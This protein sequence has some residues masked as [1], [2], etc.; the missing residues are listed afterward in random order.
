MGTPAI[1]AELSLKFKAAIEKR[2][3]DGYSPMGVAGGKGSS[4]LA[5]AKDLHIDQRRLNSWVYRQRKNEAAGKEHFSPDWNLW[6]RAATSRGKPVIA[7]ARRWLLTACQNDTPVHAGFWKNLTAYAEHIGAEI[8]VGPFTYQ[9]G[10]FT[11]HTTRNN[12]FAEQVRPF[13]RFDR[14]ECGN[15]LFCAE[16][17]TLPTAN[18]PL[19]GLQTYTR[20]QWGVFP[21]AKV[22]LETVPA[23]PGKDPPIIMTTGCCTVE[24]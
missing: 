16:M 7:A 11:D 1:A 13:L 12:V 4:V 15:V 2:L 10:T 17:N 21:H 3:R 8:L 22:A 23:M 19:S 14:Q 20:G 6:N 24:H 5:A 9:L 18:R